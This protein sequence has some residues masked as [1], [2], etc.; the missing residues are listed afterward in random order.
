VPDPDERVN[1]M[2]IKGAGEIGATGVNAAIANAV[3]NATGVR[4]RSLPI[5]LDELLTP[6]PP[7]RG[8]G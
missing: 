8:L 4:V 2:G 3:F 1:E 7:G 5:R 6:S